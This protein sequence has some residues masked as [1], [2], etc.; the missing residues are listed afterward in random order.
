MTFVLKIF[1]LFFFRKTEF[2]TRLQIFIKTLGNFCAKFMLKNECHKNMLYSVLFEKEIH[3]IS[4]FAFIDWIS[5][6]SSL[7]VYSVVF[8]PQF[9]IS[10]IRL[11][12]VPILLHL[13]FTAN[14]ETNNCDFELLHDIPVLVLIQH[15]RLGN[16]FYGTPF[17]QF[18]CHIR[19]AFLLSKKEFS[20]GSA[21]CLVG[22]TQMFI[23]F[24]L[25]FEC[26]IM[27]SNGYY[28]SNAT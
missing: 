8:W 3:L 1:F 2:Q 18:V 22:S 19:I 15:S 21:V 7:S 14:K 28:I 5:S 26:V 10:F 16:F 20:I 4:G 12:S 13:I 27:Y 11:F 24:Q 9:I 23:N 6:F 25:T 17:T